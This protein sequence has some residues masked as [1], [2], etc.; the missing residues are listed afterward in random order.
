MLVPHRTFS[1]PEYRY[2]FQGQEKD[3]EIKGSGNSINY[4]F[5]M[6]DPRVGRFFA[7]DPLGA[8][9]PHYT[10]Y[11]FSGN[12]VIA[13]AELE[14]LEEGWVIDKGTVKKVE[15][16]IIEA[17]DSER[18]AQIANSIGTQTPS[19]FSRRLRTYEFLRNQTQYPVKPSGTVKA[20]MTAE[21]MINARPDMFPGVAGVMPGVEAIV[22]EQAIIS[23]VSKLSKMRQVWKASKLARKS[24]RLVNPGGDLMAGGEFLDDF[25][26][27]RTIPP[28][29]TSQTTKIGNLVDDV[30]AQ[31]D[32]VINGSKNSNHLWEVL[33]P[34]KNPEKIK[35]IIV[36]VLENGKTIKYGQSGTA[37]VL[38]IT[39]NGTTRQ[40]KA[41]F[42]E[43]AN[44]GVE[45]FGNA[46][47]TP[48]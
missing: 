15:G 34:D 16:P 5:R 30:F 23:T 10:P 29:V 37:K 33:V 38:D 6:Y 45:Y 17:F 1:S 48:E 26:R 39:E 4:K 8:K 32:H 24:G 42:V 9:Y 40:V 41:T 2:G 35:A 36:D 28:P 47:V 46:F 14:G 31:S 13:F 43:D 3:D 18:T 21:E 22:F 7:V 12:K 20:T 19:D 11:S 44:G 25:A 27:M